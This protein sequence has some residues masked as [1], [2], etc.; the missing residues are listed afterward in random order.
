MFRKS[1]NIYTAFEELLHAYYVKM[2]ITMHFDHVVTRPSKPCMDDFLA[3][4]LRTFSPVRTA[5]FP[6]C[7]IGF[8]NDQILQSVPIWQ[9]GKVRRVDSGLGKRRRRPATVS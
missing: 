9:S 6:P 2:H 8:E 5:T 7:H 1:D 3:M 4:L